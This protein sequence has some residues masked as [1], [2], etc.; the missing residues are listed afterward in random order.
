M[1]PL[2]WTPELERVRLS[3]T[4]ATKRRFNSVLLN[5]YRDGNDTVGWHADNEE[6]LG[7]QP[8]IA[9][10]SLGA[11]R[12]FQ[13][14]RIDDPK[15]SKLTVP[16]PSGSLLVMGG[17]TQTNWHHAVPRRKRVKTPRVNLTFRMF[18]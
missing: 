3:V 10:I 5:Y 8:F 14:R 11:E 15:G 18:E 12:D 2:P 9:S 16:L 7:L 13:L 6:G 17:E 1:Q 4:R